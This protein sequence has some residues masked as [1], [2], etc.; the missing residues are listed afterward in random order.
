MATQQGNCPHVNNV[1]INHLFKQDACQNLW[2]LFSIYSFMFVKSASCFHRLAP[3]ETFREI[4][5]IIVF[6]RRLSQSKRVSQS[7]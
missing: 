2:Y 3:V 1:A 4:E 6:V 5:L 7:M